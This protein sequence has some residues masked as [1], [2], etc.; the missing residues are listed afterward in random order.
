MDFPLIAAGSGE[1][2]LGGAGGEDAVLLRSCPAPNHGET[3]QIQSKRLLGGAG[4]GRRK[5]LIVN[6]FFIVS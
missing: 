5:S 2:A 3:L 6:M 4:V 1:S